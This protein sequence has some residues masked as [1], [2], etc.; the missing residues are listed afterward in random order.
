MLKFAL[1]PCVVWVALALCGCTTPGAMSNTALDF[2]ET[3][4]RTSDS[5]ILLNIVRATYRNPTHYSAITLVRDSRTLQG[6]AGATA[7]FPFGPDVTHA[8]SVT[9]SLSATGTLSPSF[10]LAPLDNREAANG[11]FHPID[12]QV[13][14]TY[15]Q[16][17]WPPMVLLFMFVDD[18]II[19]NA[20]KK[21]CGLGYVRGNRI[22]NAAYDLKQ[23]ELTRKL[24]ECLAPRMSV[25]PDT[26]TTTFLKQASVPPEKVLKS[27]VELDKADFDVVEGNKD[28]KKVY[29]VSKT[30]AHWKFVL[31]LGRHTRAITS[32]KRSVLNDPQPS[33]S[34]DFRSVDG[35]VYYLGEIIRL[36]EHEHKLMTIPGH[37]GPHYSPECFLM[38][39]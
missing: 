34:F 24:F 16:Q 26:T 5:Q 28:G 10:D 37:Y 21:I 20:A 19:N 3:V 38:S 27:L 11:L 35:M 32:D 13:P 31:H 30:K 23:F 4:A 17:N 22:D 7:N 8:Y 9:P 18:V 12:P 29:T 36:Q 15:W 14:R 2:N 6:T 25:V 1:P 33:V 39:R